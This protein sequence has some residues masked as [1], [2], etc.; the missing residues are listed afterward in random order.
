MA[1]IQ[2]SVKSG[3]LT[4]R[5]PDGA[6]GGKRGDE[7]G[8]GRGGERGG[9]R[10]GDCAARAMM[11]ALARVPRRAPVVA[12]VHGFRFSPDIRR[13]DPHGTLYAAQD[14]AGWP[15]A[16]GF[17]ADGAQDGLCIG[18]GWDAR[19]GAGR[20]GP[21]LQR[22]PP[23]RAPQEAGPHGEGMGLHAG[24]LHGALPGARPGALHGALHEAQAAF[25][26]AKAAPGAAAGSVA[27]AAAAGL[28]AAALR[29]VPDLGFAQV[30]AR[31]AEAGRSLGALIGAIHD[32]RPDLTV[33]ILAHS[34]GARAA[35]H[36]LSAPGVGRV[37]LL[38]AAEHAAIARALLPPARLGGPEVINII[39]RHNDL[40]DAIFEAAAPAPTLA[41]PG[42]LGRAGLGAQAR[43]WIDLQI[44][45]PALEAFL[46]NRG[47]PLGPAPRS[48]CHRGFY[49]RDGAMQLWR[50]MLRER[51]R[52][53]PEA[54]RLAGAPHNPRPRPSGWISQAVEALRGRAGAPPPL[55]TGARHGAAAR[56]WH[57]DA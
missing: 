44:D 40:F 16:L 31:A 8:G 23:R 5:G 13:H 36:A 50:A 47:L 19:G 41:A 49:Q 3:G 17:T 6:R 38:G 39:A 34:L 53:S 24:G 46:A 56:R 51:A 43:N 48:I 30:Y 32:A 37:I 1:V 22:A 52:W 45:D 2:V 18:F 21:E 54:L 42:A 35:L 11:A 20:A 14:P 33:D 55:S 12:L 26:R 25:A 7:D 10:G 29:L 9:E 28:R 15:A 4:L 57:G 27:A